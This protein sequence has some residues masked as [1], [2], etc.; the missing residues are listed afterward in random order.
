MTMRKSDSK[1]DAR[2]VRHEDEDLAVLAQQLHG[3]RAVDA[4]VFHF[5]EQHDRRAANHR[6]VGDQQRPGL[7][8]GKFRHAVVQVDRFAGQLVGEIDRLGH[9]WLRLVAADRDARMRHQELADRQIG[10]KRRVLRDQ[11]DRVFRRIVAEIRRRRLAVDQ[12]PPAAGRIAV[13]KQF[14]VVDERRLA[15]AGR[16]DNAHDLPHGH[17]DP[18]ERF[19]LPILA[20]PAEDR[21]GF[22]HD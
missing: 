1:R 19:G 16:T 18:S 8:A 14:D 21:N 9:Q 11:R 15:G 2:I 13:G 12:N 5:V 7:A 22:D 4:G 6:G 3:P 10:K 20:V 17:V